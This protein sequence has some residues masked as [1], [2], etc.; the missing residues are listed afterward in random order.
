LI[1]TWTNGEWRSDNVAR[2]SFG[3]VEVPTAAKFERA[4][5]LDASLL[6][7]IVHK[8]R[9]LDWN[10]GMSKLPAIHIWFKEA[11]ILDASSLDKPSV[12]ETKRINGEMFYIHRYAARM[13]QK[14]TP[15]IIMQ[16]GC[17]LAGWLKQSSHQ[18]PDFKNQ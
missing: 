7:G 18:L 10:P 4:V 15:A 8:D 1:G 16:E 11:L 3:Q 14:R 12:T 6:D 17:E 9:L 2:L 13:R 5:V